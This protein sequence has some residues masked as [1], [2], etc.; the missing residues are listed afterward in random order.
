[1]KSATP[2]TALCGEAPGRDLNLGRVSK[3][4]VDQQ[5]HTLTLEASCLSYE[6]KRSGLLVGTTVLLGIVSLLCRLYEFACQ[7]LI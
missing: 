2:Q 6:K 5:S 7:C 1:M 4:H 3:R